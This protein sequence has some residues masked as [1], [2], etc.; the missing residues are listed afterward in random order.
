[1]QLT[2]TDTTGSNS[3]VGVGLASLV[4]TTIEWYDFLL[5]GT[6]AALVFNRL[7]F[8]EFDPAT[9]TLAALGT[10][11][12]GYL[13]RPIGAALFGHLASFFAELFGARL[14]YTGVSLGFSDRRSARG[15]P[16]ARHR[17]QP[18]RVI[19][20]PGTGRAVHG[21]TRVAFGHLRRGSVAAHGE[22]GVQFGRGLRAT[23]EV[24]WAS[25]AV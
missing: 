4:G 13:A 15:W 1:M 21:R 7:V 17:R 19:R 22:P 20:E 5:Y 2:H 16:V 11:A 25:F 9:G 10:F 3:I 12:A 8:P 6:A 24:S 14:R 18:G 23:Q